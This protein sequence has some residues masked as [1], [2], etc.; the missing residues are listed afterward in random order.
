MPG[1]R[2]LEGKGDERNLVRSWGS[3]EFLILSFS[4]PAPDESG[5]L[6]QLILGRGR[7]SDSH[8]SLIGMEDKSSQL[9]SLPLGEE[10]L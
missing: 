3:T 7:G 5:R 2:R 4:C 1:P 6:P 10:C 9:I 8:E